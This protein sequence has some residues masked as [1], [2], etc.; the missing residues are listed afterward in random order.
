[1]NETCFSRRK[2]DKL[3]V[4]FLPMSFLKKRKKRGLTVN[5][6]IGSPPYSIKKKAK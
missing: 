2:K 3:E 4:V 6:K 5:K 1:M